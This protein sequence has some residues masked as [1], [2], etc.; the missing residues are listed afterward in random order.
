MFSDAEAHKSAKTR[1]IK[2]KPLERRR[3]LKEV[4]LTSSTAYA[5]RKFDELPME[6]KVDLN[7]VVEREELKKQQGIP[8][9]LQ[10]E[11]MERGTR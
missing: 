4:G 2:A 6:V 5:Y 8:A 10:P 1:W 7:Y 3:M 11:L 9:P